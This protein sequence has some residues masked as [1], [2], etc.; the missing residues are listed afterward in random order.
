MGPCS[1]VVIRDGQPDVLYEV[2]RVPTLDRLKEPGQGACCM[3]G[4][5]GAGVVIDDERR[6]A[7][8]L[9]TYAGTENLLGLPRVTVV[10]ATAKEQVNRAR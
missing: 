1:P 5:D 7:E 10:V 4:Q 3:E 6:I 2:G 9:Q 8:S